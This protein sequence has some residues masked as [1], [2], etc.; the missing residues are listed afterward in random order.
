[1]GERRNAP[2]RVNYDRQIQM[3]FQGVKV[4]SDAGL[5]ALR[6]LDD[7]FGLTEN[8][9]DIFFDPR[10]GKNKQHDLKSLFRQSVF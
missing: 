6:E 7:T 5:L 10:I 9:E 4:T 3:E 2:L 8:M 1:L